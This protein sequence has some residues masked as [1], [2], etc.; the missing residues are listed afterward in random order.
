MP[1]VAEARPRAEPTTIALPEESP[2]PLGSHPD[3]SGV[4]E[5]L[6]GR[7]GVADAGGNRGPVSEE[8]RRDLKR[9]LN[10]EKNVN[11]IVG[12]LTVLGQLDGVPFREAAEILR[13]HPQRLERWIH[14]TETIPEQKAESVRQLA[15]VLRALHRVLDR[16]ATARWLHTPI[17]SLG[18]ATP[19]D[20]MV[21]GDLPIVVGL[22]SSYI[23]P[24]AYS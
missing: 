1:P 8:A 23:Q 15:D 4:W 20:L 17:P 18:A 6:F 12:L 22:T 19:F 7:L 21:R 5:G 2:V 11:R 10:S 16:R 3:V 24:V 13:V 9:R 14:L